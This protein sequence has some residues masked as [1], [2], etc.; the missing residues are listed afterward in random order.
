MIQLNRSHFLLSVA[1]WCGMLQFVV[2]IHSAMQV[3]DGGYS[4]GHNF[5]SDLGRTVSLSGMPKV[6]LPLAR[7]HFQVVV[8][9]SRESGIP[10]PAASDN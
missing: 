7:W 6:N 8:D 4:V 3:Y 1:A 9:L 5:L 10:A 2:C